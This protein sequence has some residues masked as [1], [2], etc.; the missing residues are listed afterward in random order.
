M[1]EYKQYIHLDLSVHCI[2]TELRRHYHHGI[3]AY[4]KA[5]EQGKARLGPT[6]ASLQQILETVDFRRMRSTHPVLAGGADVEAVLYY[7]GDSP[8][9]LADNARINFESG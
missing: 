3:G 8:F 1:K 7:D 6:I 9:I 2:E 4:F 5:D